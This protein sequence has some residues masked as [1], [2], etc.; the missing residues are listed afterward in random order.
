MM[1]Y[2]HNINSIYN[3]N[4]RMLSPK[5]TWA[6]F[7]YCV[8]P[9]C[10]AAMPRTMARL[11]RSLRSTAKAPIAVGVGS[12]GFAP[13]D[14]LASHARPPPPRV[15]GPG[16]LGHPG[17]RGTPTA[18]GAGGAEPRAGPRQGRGG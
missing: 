18:R 10:V 7:A 17:L 4:G 8:L 2:Y 11:Q 6:C 1:Y 14:P 12:G 9:H 16:H 15:T 3:I 13:P 5:S